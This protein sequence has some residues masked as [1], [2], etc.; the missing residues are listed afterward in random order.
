VANQIQPL[1]WLRITIIFLNEIWMNGILKFQITIYFPKPYS[2]RTCPVSQGIDLIIH[3]EII[4]LTTVPKVPARRG[5][6]S[7]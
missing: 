1:L 6:E 4:F 2:S 5:G 3:E 7:I